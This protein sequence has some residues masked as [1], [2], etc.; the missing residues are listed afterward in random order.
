LDYHWIQKSIVQNAT[1]R[2]FKRERDQL[3]HI[4]HFYIFLP[5][6]CTST[7][8]TDL[9]WDDFLEF[10][11]LIYSNVTSLEHAIARF[12]DL[13][14]FLDSWVV[15]QKKGGYTWLGQNALNQVAEGYN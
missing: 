7:Q 12:L 13:L 6:A 3:N 4:N 11:N 1:S 14:N 2:T 15:Y 8:D 10:Y 5:I 9:R